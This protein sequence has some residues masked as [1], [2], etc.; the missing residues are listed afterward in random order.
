MLTGNMPVQLHETIAKS[1]DQLDTLKF[2]SDDALHQ[3]ATS[4]RDEVTQLHQTIQAL[5]D[6]LEEAEKS[7]GSD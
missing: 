6:K 5:R 4:H 2:T 1:R 3:Q 7:A